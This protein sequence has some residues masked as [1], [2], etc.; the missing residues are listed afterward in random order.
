MS[1]H[2]SEDLCAQASLYALGI[3][4]GSEL[5]A[6]KHHLSR[7]CITCKTELEEFSSV[8]D[9]LGHAAPSIAPPPS[10]RTT[11]LQRIKNHSSSDEKHAP[12]ET[13][14]K[15]LEADSI[16]IKASEGLWQEILPGI[17]LK[18]LFMDEQQ[19]RMTALAR[20]SANTSYAAHRHIAPE[21]CYMLEGACSLDGRLLQPGDYH[22]AE[23]G[24]IHHETFTKDGCL[25]LIIF[26]PNNEMLNHLP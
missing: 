11:L 12:L 22:R 23:T 25:M 18:P 17:K 5:I 8:V 24:S 26:S 16:F 9:Q 19:G 3:L 2:E 21:E 14:T 1:A 13:N 20:L 4:E 6:Y 10:L 7:G 15:K